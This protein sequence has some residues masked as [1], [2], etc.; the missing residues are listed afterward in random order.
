MTRMQQYMQLVKYAELCWASYSEGLNEGMFGNEERKF[1]NRNSEI[2]KERANNNEDNPTYHQAL[3]ESQ[4]LIFEKYNVG[5]SDSQANHFI[6]R[7]EV[8]AFSQDNNTGFSAT[9]F[10]DTEDNEYILAIRGIDIFRI[11]WNLVNAVK[12]GIKI[13]R[14][15]VSINY[16]LSLLRFYDK[17]VKPIIQ[18]KKLTITGHVF[19]G[20]LAQLFAL[21]FPDKVN[22]VYTF[23]ATGVTQNTTTQYV[24]MAVNIAN[25]ITKQVAFDF[26]VYDSNLDEFVSIQVDER[27]K[28]NVKLDEGLLVCNDKEIQDKIPQYLQREFLEKHFNTYNSQT[29]KLGASL[30]FS[31]IHKAEI[32][33]N[34]FVKI[35]LD[36]FIPHTINT[37][38]FTLN[39][40]LSKAVDNLIAYLPNSHKELP[41]ALQQSE[42]Y[43]IYTIDIADTETIMQ[44]FGNHILPS[45]TI[46]LKLDAVKLITKF[47]DFKRSGAVKGALKAMKITNVAGWLIILVSIKNIYDELLVQS[48]ITEDSTPMIDCY[49]CG[50]EQ[51]MLLR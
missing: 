31:E 50:W 32:G 44:Q 12:S 39:Q 49:W 25:E 8:L 30:L 20:Y 23:N 22:K 43:R 15:K 10:Y 40:E 17:K 28:N 9:L 47:D 21:S 46:E 1:G 3:S 33:K 7:F 27:L 36:G 5:F 24:N 19:G 18:D 38:V 51:L 41:P 6:T 48:R 2:F 34:I 16:Y 14:G 45:E 29:A 37:E 35:H 26:S 4:Y 42:I 13:I 11:N